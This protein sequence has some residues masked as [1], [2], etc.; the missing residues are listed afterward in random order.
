[1]GYQSLGF[2]VFSAVV[3]LMYYLVGRKGQLWVLALANLAFYAIAGVKYIPFIVA[4]MLVTYLA[5]RSIGKIYDKADAQIATCTDSAEKKKLR[6][7]AKKKAKRFVVAAILVPLALLVVC[8]YTGFIVDNLNAVLVRLNVPQITLMQIVLPLGISFYTFMA[9]SYVLDIYWKRYKA[10]KNFL[11]YAVYLSYFPHVVQGPI[12]RF[13]E[14][15]E[16][17]KDGVGCSWQNLTFGAQLAIWGLFKKLVVADRLGLFVD[18]VFEHYQDYDG[19]IIMIAV[20][21]YSIQIYADFSGC[22]DIVTG[23]SEMFGIKLRKNFNHPYFSRTMPEFWRRWH[24]SLQEWF[25]DYVY[26]PVSASELTKK[27]KKHF[28]NKGNK[29]AAELFATCFPIIIVW[30]ITGIWHGAAWRFVIWGMF[31]AALLVGGVLFEPLFKKL[32][33]LFKLDTENFG[34]H[35]WQMT[36]TYILCCIGRVFFRAGGLMHGLRML[37]M[38]VKS[39]HISVLFEKDKF[40]GIEPS[41]IFMA[42]VAVCVLLVVDIMQEKISIRETLAKQNIVFRW[43]IIFAGIFSVIIFGIYGPGYD[44]SSFIYEQF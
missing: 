22:I 13:N 18:D 35:F 29:K 17:V 41:N 43:V 23:V 7:E 40:Y 26:Y 25:K 1:M 28:N 19:M 4:T 30:M 11:L 24:I 20:A 21:V 15:K 2:M 14:F 33:E 12:D 8:K 37:Y 36:R 34:W 31:H 44:L 9:L 6:A 16:Q 38:M 5:G 42:I 27:V 3:L 32:T 10:E 39:S